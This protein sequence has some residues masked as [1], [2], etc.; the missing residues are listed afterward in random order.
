[1]E[2]TLIKEVRRSEPTVSA[3]RYSDAIRRYPF[4]EMEEE[5]CLAKSWRE[6]GDRASIDKL[7]VSHL[8]LVV[9]IAAGFRGYRFPLSDLI[10]EGNFGLIQA[11]E[12]FDPEMGVRFST[13]ATWWIKA[14]IR[15]YALHTWSMVK[16]GTTKSQKTLFYKLRTAKNRIAALGDDL[17]YDQAVR[18]AQKLGVDA[19]EV[20]DMDRRLAGDVSLNVP[21]Y[22]EGKG[23]ERM[24]SL[25]DDSR[26]PEDVLEDSEQCH[27]R[28][29]ALMHALSG[30]TVRER[31]IFVARRLLDDPI[32]LE[33]LASE[34]GIS[35][36]RVRQIELRVFAKVKSRI[37]N[38]ATTLSINDFH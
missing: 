4:L 29:R 32:G 13:Y 10:A 34:F 8:R 23:A 16:I 2:P 37:T 17:Q 11:A 26:N 1:M 31:R 3:A 35:K 30:L 19:R 7:I 12:R 28:H 33:A 22:D 36:E 25:V 27:Q 24:D 20:M 18:I 38:D 21:I 6:R 15:E 5:R 9:R 14:R